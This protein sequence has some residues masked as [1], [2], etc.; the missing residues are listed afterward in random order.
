MEMAKQEMEVTRG[1]LYA[2]RLRHMT[3]PTTA[4]MRRWR[5]ARLANYNAAIREYWAIAKDIAE[6][7]A[8]PNV[9]GHD[10]GRLLL[11]ASD[12]PLSQQ[13]HFIM[14]SRNL[15][16]AFIDAVIAY[17]DVSIGM[18]D[19]VSLTHLRL[20]ATVSDR[21]VRR[22]LFTDIRKNKLSVADVKA[23]LKERSEAQKEAA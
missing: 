23:W 9:Y 18:H 5:D 17:N 2:I 16:D 7:T 8:S 15:D 22:K 4:V 14:A 1:Q 13:R 12:I 21:R 20:I 3:M 19:I 11:N 10:A 6:V